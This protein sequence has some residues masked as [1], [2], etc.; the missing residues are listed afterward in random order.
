MKPDSDCKAQSGDWQR[1]VPNRLADVSAA[2]AAAGDFLRRHGVA[3][4]AAHAVHLALEEL[5]TNTVRYGRPAGPSRV[6]LVI[7]TDAV[8]ARLEDDGGAFNPLTVPAPDLPPDLDARTPGG[9]GIH[10]VRRLVSGL[11][12]ERRAGRNLVTVTVAR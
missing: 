11:D 6:A 3:E 4:A 5:L 1:E 2:A 7:R 12:Y 8:V 9:L 10:L